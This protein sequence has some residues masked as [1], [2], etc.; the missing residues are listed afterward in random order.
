VAVIAILLDELLT[1]VADQL[2][3]MNGPRTVADHGRTAIDRIRVNIA[4]HFR[5]VRLSLIDSLP[6]FQPER[7]DPI[8]RPNQN[9]A[10]DHSSR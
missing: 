6:V 4:R 3:V 8:E 9:L 10:A 5:D 7:Y 1:G 2:T